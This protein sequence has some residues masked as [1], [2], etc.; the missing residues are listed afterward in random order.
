MYHVDDV[1]QMSD[2]ICKV[3]P[4]GAPV[5]ALLSPRMTSRFLYPGYF[6]SKRPYYVYDFAYGL[7]ANPM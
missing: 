6:E 1:G 5:M 7:D 3:S 2:L 4:N